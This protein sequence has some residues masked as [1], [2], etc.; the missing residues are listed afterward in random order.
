M[1]LHP[2]F[3]IFLFDVH[4]EEVPLQLQIELLDLWCS[5]DLK[6]KFLA[7]Y[8][9][10]FYKNHMFLSGWILIRITHTQ[11]VVSMFGTT[12]CCKQLFS[13]MK[14]AKSML[15]LQL[16]NHL[17][18]DVFLLSTSSFNPDITCCLNFWD[19]V[20]YLAFDPAKNVIPR[21]CT[22]RKWHMLMAIM[23]GNRVG[24]NWLMKWDEVKKFPWYTHRLMHRKRVT[25]EQLFPLDDN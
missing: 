1:A 14:H 24:G 17:L 4:C 11:Q 25:C 10:N 16:S 7:C 23:R 22:G 13:K 20:L 21:W 3:K 8:I 6:S 5:E 15:H 12:Y 9:L 19:K 2:N 18:S